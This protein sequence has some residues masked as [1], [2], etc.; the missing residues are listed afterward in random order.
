MTVLPQKAGRKWVGHL[1]QFLRL[2]ETGGKKDAHC[3]LSNPTQAWLLASP[4]VFFLVLFFQ[5]TA[6]GDL[7][8]VTGQINLEWSPAWKAQTNSLAYKV[9]FRSSG[10][11]PQ[12]KPES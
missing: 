3:H 8:V 6:W 7:G 2:G 11:S 5:L 12:S 1:Y 9:V 10:F 4:Y